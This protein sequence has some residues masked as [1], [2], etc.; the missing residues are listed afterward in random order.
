MAV[1]LIELAIT[2]QRHTAPPEDVL[3]SL[4]EP[5]MNMLDSLGAPSMEL[6]SGAGMD[7]ISVG[8]EIRVTPLFKSRGQAKQAVLAMGRQKWLVTSWRTDQ[9]AS[10]RVV[11]SS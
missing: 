1:G 8:C 11:E 3:P 2:L 7:P 4:G 10:F 9:S 5:L 6:F